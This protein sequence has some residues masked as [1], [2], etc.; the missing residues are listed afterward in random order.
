MMAV[1]GPCEA[2]VAVLASGL[3]CAASAPKTSTVVM[4][5]I[6]LRVLTVQVT[7]PN[8]QEGSTYYYK[9]G[10]PTK[11]NGVS[12]VFHFKVLVT[13][14]RKPSFP[15]LDIDRMLVFIAFVDLTLTKQHSV[16]QHV[17]QTQLPVDVELELSLAGP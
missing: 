15:C 11:P 10:D 1:I 4:R 2:R 13:Q 17:A 14:A 8:L 6:G 5:S 7:V 12:P 3:V 9:V 16:R